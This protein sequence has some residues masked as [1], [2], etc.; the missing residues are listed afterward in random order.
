MPF[1]S[2]SSSRRVNLAQYYVTAKERYPNR[3][4]EYSRTRRAKYL[5]EERARGREYY[6]RN[7]EERV[8]YRRRYCADHPDLLAEQWER[9]YEANRD[10]EHERK[11]KYRETHKEECAAYRRQYAVSHRQEFAAWSRERR[12]R[13]LN[14]GGSHTPADIVAQYE[15]QRGKC[16]WCHDA[17]GE[18]YH[19]DHV[20]PL[21]LGG[22]NGPE[23]LV[24]ACPRC[25]QSKNA[26]HPMDFAGVML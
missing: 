17:V 12:A 13:K 22:S 15:R 23:N 2:T 10:R 14:N 1:E 9:Y 16:Y 4:A 25:N 20:M 24:V 6:K 3:V 7:R 19:V 11:A 5:E 21:A 18:T 8:E 26:K